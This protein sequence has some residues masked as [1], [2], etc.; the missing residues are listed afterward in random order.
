MSTLRGRGS[1]RM[2][3]LTTRTYRPSLWKSASQVR[4]FPLIW[5]NSTFRYLKSPASER[6]DGIILRENE[7]VASQRSE[8]EK[9]R[10]RFLPP[11]PL[12]ARVEGSE[13]RTV[14][15]DG[16][17]PPTTCQE[18]SL[19]R[20]SPPLSPTPP[21]TP[22]IDGALL[23]VPGEG[24]GNVFRITAKS[25]ELP[26]VAKKPRI[27]PFFISPK[28]DWRQLVA[29]AKAN[30]PLPSNHKCRDDSKGHC[31]RRCRLQGP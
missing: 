26:V 20:S 23:E 5:P 11:L 25:K 27:P 4:S 19:S 2:P 6:L 21:S 15:S 9:S 13:E 3:N 22:A 29:L 14:D 8:R 28:G 17:V 18:S 7:N 1:S 24:D 10:Q 12:P 16:F 31:G 30:R